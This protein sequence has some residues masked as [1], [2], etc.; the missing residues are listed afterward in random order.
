MSSNLVIYKS[1]SKL[2]QHIQADNK[3]CSYRDTFMG[4]K[5]KMKKKLGKCEPY[6]ILYFLFHSHKFLTRFNP[7]KF[8]KC[9]PDV[10]SNQ[11]DLT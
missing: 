1:N 10:I 3:S 7:L 8:Q 6:K 11:Y 2:F 4:H 5:I 9:K